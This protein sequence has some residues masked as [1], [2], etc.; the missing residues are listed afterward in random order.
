MNGILLIGLG[1]FGCMALGYILQF[2]KA[3]IMEII[4]HHEKKETLEKHPQDSWIY[5]I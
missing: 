1:T 2:I 5:E 3:G 4:Y